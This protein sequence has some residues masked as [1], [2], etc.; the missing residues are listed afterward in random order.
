MLGKLGN[1]RSFIVLGDLNYPNIDW[2]NYTAPSH[3]EN[4]F[5][6]FVNE[7]NLF[8]FVSNPTRGSKPLI[9]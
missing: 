7:N 6:S 9:F 8:Q 1:I 3:D 4:Y 5:L 2:Q